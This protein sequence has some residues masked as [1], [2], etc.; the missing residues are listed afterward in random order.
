M[1]PFEELIDYSKCAPDPVFFNSSVNIASDLIIPP[2]LESVS[3]TTLLPENA[4]PFQDGRNW[5]SSS[6]DA[7]AAPPDPP[8]ELD[9]VV[10]NPL[11]DGCEKRGQ[12]F[13]CTQDPNKYAIEHLSGG[14]SSHMEDGA[15]G[16][17]A[18]FPSFTGTI[19]SPNPQEQV[20][21][22]R[23]AAS[24]H[25]TAQRSGLLATGD[26]SQVSRP[27][28]N[29]T[30]PDHYTTS[31]KGP[32]EGYTSKRK[33]TLEQ[34]KVLKKWHSK[35]MHDPYPNKSEKQSLASQTKLSLR[36]VGVWFNNARKRHQKS[37]GG[38]SQLLQT[39]RILDLGQTPM[40]RYL[41]SSSDDEPANPEDISSAAFDW[42]ENDPF[43][44]AS[45]PNAP[46]PPDPASDQ[47]DVMSDLPPGYQGAQKAWL[48]R[49]KLCWR[50]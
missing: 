20:D 42:E 21:E 10:G 33:F 27:N 18:R 6:T 36:Q 31:T 43:S 47:F 23:E 41:S 1:D 30:S 35:P 13:T 32:N 29:S 24:G 25:R 8:I 40:E 34:R 38:E 46:E 7:L 22:T 44:F 3:P 16:R 37:I 4:P 15:Y 5:P 45:F 19:L 39:D 28:S 9:Q 17:S 2:P 14:E 12:S 48:L 11:W 26:E 49:P 50:P